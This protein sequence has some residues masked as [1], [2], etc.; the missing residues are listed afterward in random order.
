MPHVRQL[1]TSVNEANAEQVHGFIHENCRITVHKLT[2]T[3]GISVGSVETIIHDELNFSKV[4]AVPKLL[5]NEQK[6]RRV[7]IYTQLLDNSEGEGDPF[8]IQ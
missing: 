3:V 1:R 5:S 7:Q 4:S 6:E 2:K 8:C